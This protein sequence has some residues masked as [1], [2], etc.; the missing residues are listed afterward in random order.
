M[1]LKLVAVLTFTILGMVFPMMAGAATPFDA[2]A[3][4]NFAG[5]SQID[6]NLTLK[7]ANQEMQAGLDPNPAPI[8]GFLD[9]GTLN[10]LTGV[11]SGAFRDVTAAT[12]ATVERLKWQHTISAT[13][14]APA[15]TG[16]FIWNQ[17]RAI[18][19]P[20]NIAVT[21]AIDGEAFPTFSLQGIPLRADYEDGKLTIASGF[22]YTNSYK[23]VEFTLTAAINLGGTL[24]TPT[25]GTV[26]VGLRTDA[27]A[28]QSGEVMTLYASLE[29][30]G[31]SQLVDLYIALYAPDGIL[32]C[33]PAYTPAFVPIV[34]GWAFESGV[35][36][37][38]TL[39]LSSQLPNELPIPM[40]DGEYI[41]LAA[42]FKPGT[43]DLIGEVAVASFTYTAEMPVPQTFD[44]IWSGT[45]T[46][47]V[48]SV[49]CRGIAEL[50][51][52]VVGGNL[53]GQAVLTGSADD[54]DFPVAATV[55]AGGNIVN[56]T[57]LEEF[58]NQLYQI[59]TFTGALGADTGEGKW[60]D[61]YGCY[62]TFSVTRVPG[63]GLGE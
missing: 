58:A 26:W 25:A 57:I 51:F 35:K 20:E 5:G 47:L 29:N 54:D 22:E 39:L 28:Y 52:H 46:S 18:I 45:A 17:N 55:D 60:Y 48:D 14:N 16:V 56:G 2:P 8:A 49:D 27:N 6:L 44:G 62:G 19:Y 12:T 31:A 15:L 59:G 34:A 36:I 11:F 63:T 3:T 21:I 23:G 38:Y 24:Q 53:N 13:L 30:S 42:F 50:T 43:T 41:W 37:P 4:F 33:L 9:V 40:M 32:Y 61:D 10:K 7:V 1:K